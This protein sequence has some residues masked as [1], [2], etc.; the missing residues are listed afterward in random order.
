M[1][2]A[3]RAK[4]RR[5]WKC[6]RPSPHKFVFDL[7]HRNLALFQLTLSPPP[8]S[9]IPRGSKIPHLSAN[10]RLSGH[11]LPN[12]SDTRIPRLSASLCTSL[13]CSNATDQTPSP[14]SDPDAQRTMHG[15]PKLRTDDETP[16]QEVPTIR[17]REKAKAKLPVSIIA[18]VGDMQVLDLYHLTTVSKCIKFRLEFHLESVSTMRMFL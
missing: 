16:L 12:Y 5:P 13:T 14:R 11:P 3:A 6:P 2:D 9:F 4:R 17:D 18:A 15:V 8:V 1:K 10:A 7:L